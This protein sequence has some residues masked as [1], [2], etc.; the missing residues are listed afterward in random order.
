MLNRGD[1]VIVGTDDG[2]SS[3]DLRSVAWSSVEISRAW[4]MVGSLDMVNDNQW[5]DTER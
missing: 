1:S 2:K 3:N 5:M 4:L